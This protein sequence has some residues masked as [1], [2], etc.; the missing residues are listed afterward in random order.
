[1]K[2]IARITFTSLLVLVF[3]F[4]FAQE[5]AK[6]QSREEKKAEK[7]LKKKQKEE[8]EQANWVLMQSIAKNKR[9]VVEFDRVNNTQTG[10]P[11]ILNRRL[12]FVAVNGDRVTIQFETHPNLSDNGLGGRTIDGD[13]NSYKYDPPKNENRPIEINFNLS[14]KNTFRGSNVSIT[15]SEGGTATI[16]IGSSPLIYGYFVTPENANVNMGA[17]MFD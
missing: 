5:D 11:L 4:S 14:S 8:K 1:M 9:F 15:V 17:Q 12:N 7:E 6:K 3:L 13:L 10:K 2:Q 16:T